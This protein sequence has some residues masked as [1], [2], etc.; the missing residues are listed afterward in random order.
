MVWVLFQGAELGVIQSATVAGE[1]LLER[2]K[3]LVI[4]T[5][6]TSIENQILSLLCAAGWHL[7]AAVPYSAIEPDYMTYTLGRITH[8]P[9]DGVQVWV[10][11]R[12]VDV[13]VLMHVCVCSCGQGGAWR[14]VT[15]L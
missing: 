2:I 3:M 12:H 7:V 1:R 10:N 5:H 15:I 13:E 14:C 11:P 6:N 9:V 4:S 8:G